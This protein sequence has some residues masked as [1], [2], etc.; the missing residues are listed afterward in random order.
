MAKN[1][2]IDKKVC[3][4]TTTPVVVPSC[5]H[6]I[7]YLVEQIFNMDENGDIANFIP[8][9]TSLLNNGWIISNNAG[10]CCPDCDDKYGFYFLG[11]LAK[12]GPIA[13]TFKFTTTAPACA[14]PCCLNIETNAGGHDS[15]KTNI[16]VTPECCDTNF[17]DQVSLMGKMIHSPLYFANM[18]LV[19]MS[20]IQGNS[21]IGV[22][23]N[24]IAKRYQGITETEWSDIFT[25]LFVTAGIAIK[26][27]DCG[28][29]IA[30]A[31]T[32]NTWAITNNYNDK[33]CS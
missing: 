2:T 11:S 19:E 15:F 1:R 25:Y 14:I 28:I 23:I 9:A 24:A 13:T 29:I 12:F 18:S 33:T 6:P 8:N 30:S 21:S 4:G 10:V 31:N 16:P 3:C 5:V 17:K 27:F 26:C 20:T 7:E 32:F 22:L